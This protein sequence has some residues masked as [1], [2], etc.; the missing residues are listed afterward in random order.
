MGDVKSRP[1]TLRAERAAVT[2]SRIERSA[3]SLFVA[4]GYGATTLREIADEAGVAVQTVY[5]VYGSKASI[6]RA[7]RDALV[8]DP[9]ADSAYAE[10]L[11]ATSVAGA[12]TAFAR[13]IRL[14]WEAGHDVVVISGDAATVDP[15]IREEAGRVLE[16][17]RR[18]IAAL[19][20]AIASLD[21]ALA[22]DHRTAAII[23]AL[24]QPEVYGTLVVDHGWT[25]DVFETWLGAALRL[26]MEQERAANRA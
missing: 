20:R 17:R 11:A 4:R 23:D 19:T 2:R 21:P 5:A 12:V 10:A 7:L 15:V 16:G 6:L 1:G 25:P 3:R 22:D 14:R 8:N 9:S 18:G 13:S 24:T 26:Q